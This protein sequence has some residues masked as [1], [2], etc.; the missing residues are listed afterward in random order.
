MTDASLRSVRL[1]TGERQ[2]S[3]QCARRGEDVQLC[4][5]EREAPNGARLGRN[6]GR[7]K[8]QTREGTLSR[9]RLLRACLDLQLARAIVSSDGK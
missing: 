4:R 3:E 6:D 1:R 7:V 2:G 9:T 5:A 8:D